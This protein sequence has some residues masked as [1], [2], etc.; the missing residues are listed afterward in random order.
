M[1]YQIIVQY[2][3]SKVP[4]SLYGDIVKAPT[5][6][7]GHIVD[8]AGKLIGGATGGISFA[9]SELLRQREKIQ[10]GDPNATFTFTAEPVAPSKRAVLSRDERLVLAALGGK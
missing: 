2:G 9:V 8:K 4:T 3:L 7:Y 10:R 5:V 6:F 1:D